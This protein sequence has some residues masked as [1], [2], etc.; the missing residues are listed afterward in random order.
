MWCESRTTCE[1]LP[2]TDRTSEE[3]EAVTWH[4]SC[5]R[6]CLPLS[7]KRGSNPEP[8]ATTTPSRS[9]M[10]REPQTGVRFWALQCCQPTE[11]TH[12][13]S[14]SQTWG[15]PVVFVQLAPILKDRKWPLVCR[16]KACVMTSF[17]HFIILGAF[18]WPD[19]LL[20]FPSWCKRKNRTYITKR[21][22][23]SGETAY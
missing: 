5:S 15:M 13:R 21:E 2:W 6:G 4:V 17:L 8:H 3:R 23:L 16:V 14:H 10:F 22:C 9:R 12:W 18:Y 1:L 20:L 11:P 19:W 7:R